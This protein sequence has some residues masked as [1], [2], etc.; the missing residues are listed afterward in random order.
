MTELICIGCPKGCKLLVD[1][2]NDYKVT[3]NSCAVGEK[4]GKEELINPVRTLT[5][6]VRVID[7]MYHSL[8]VKSDKPLPKDLL[9]KAMD[10]INKVQIEA[11]ICMHQVIIEN[12]LDTDCNII[13]TRDMEKIVTK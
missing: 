8:P 4:Y 2:N 13:A 1:E 5:T 6:T 11:P 9:F 12:I 7:G 10:E 3:G